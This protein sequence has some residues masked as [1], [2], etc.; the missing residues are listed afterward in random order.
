MR[1]QGDL[2]FPVILRLS[3]FP[4]S[5]MCNGTIN[6][7][8]PMSMLFLFLFFSFLSIFLN[9]FYLHLLRFV[10]TQSQLISPQFNLYR[11]PHWSHLPQ[12]HHGS[13]CQSH[14][15]QVMAQRS[16]SVYLQDFSALP[17][18]QSIQSHHLVPL[19]AT[20]HS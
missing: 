6:I 16:L 5:R 3:K 2:V 7:L 14:I 4:N 19:S 8:F 11:I 20:S 13:R 10:Q 9:L 12:C 15:Q 17:R 1:M 18:F